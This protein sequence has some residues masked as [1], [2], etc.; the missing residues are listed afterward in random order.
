M[1]S[2]AG[3][4][5]PPGWCSA[6][7][8]AR[9]SASRSASSSCSPATTS[10][11][12]SATSVPTSSARAGTRPTALRNLLADP[13]RPLHE[14]L[15]DQRNLAGLGNMYA[16]ELAFTAGLHPFTPVGEVPDLAGLV[17]RGRQMLMANRERSQQSTTGELRRDRRTWVYRRE[18][19]GCLRCGT[20][21]QVDQLAPTGYER[22]VYWCPSCQPATSAPGHSIRT[23]SRS[24]DLIVQVPERGDPKRGPRRDR[25]GHARRRPDREV[26]APCG[27]GCAAS[28]VRHARVR[29]RER[30][31][32]LQRSG[33]A[34]CSICSPS[35]GTA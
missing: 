25:T 27:G 3:P 21:V 5:T 15:L 8:P 33:S 23:G 9:P 28:S 26:R 17:R 11:T 34:R 4:P 30:P 14:A 35:R 18:R 29:G 13:A 6:P 7:P 10:P 16:A 22:T 19:T 12:S 20:P 24:S 31:T 2:G 32:L 1:R